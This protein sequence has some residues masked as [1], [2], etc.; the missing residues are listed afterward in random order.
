MEGEATLGRPSRFGQCYASGLCHAIRIAWVLEPNAH[1]L[2]MPDGR[3]TPDWR[4]AQF[5]GVERGGRRGPIVGACPPLLWRPQHLCAA[6]EEVAER[7][8][9]DGSSPSSSCGANGAT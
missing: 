6:T 1:A 9:C 2:L 7:H 5:E 8:P 4:M 3:C